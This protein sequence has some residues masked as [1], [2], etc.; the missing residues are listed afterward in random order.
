M[1][2]DGPKAPL[3]REAFRALFQAQGERLF[4]MLYRL[5]GDAA[6]AE[7]LLQETFLAVWRKRELFEARGALEGF[8]RRTAMRQFLNFQAARSRR[9]ALA[10]PPAVDCTPEEPEEDL[11]RSDSLSFLA[12][13]VR[14]AVERLPDGARETFV[15]FRYEGLTCAEIADA[16]GAPLKTVETRLR[17]ATHLLAERL[18]PYRDEVPSV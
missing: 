13:R 18:S 1:N 16:T 6:D 5:T 15:L 3:G 11:A 7:D 17:R 4:R 10:P 12:A 8:V 2:A 14:A 9:A